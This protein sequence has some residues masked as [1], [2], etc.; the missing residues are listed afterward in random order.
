MRIILNLKNDK[1]LNKLLETLKNFKEDEIEIKILDKQVTE[2]YTDEYI[3]KNWK[4]L[5]YTSVGSFDCDDDEY[6]LKH[7]GEK[8]LKDYED[9]F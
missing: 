6:L 7:Y 1:N 2:K 8:L 4:K 5:I 3:E 9:T